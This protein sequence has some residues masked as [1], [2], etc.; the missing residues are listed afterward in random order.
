MKTLICCLAFAV[1]AVA[2]APYSM[3]FGT[4]PLRFEENR[5]QESPSVR[6]IARGSRFDVFLTKQGNVIRWPGGSVE[7]TLEGAS[8]APRIA[9]LEP[10]AVRTNYFSGNHPENWKT[11]LR[12]Y[13]KVRYADVY[14]GIDL[15]FYGREGRLEYDFLVHAGADPASIRWKFRGGDG[16]RIGEKG[17]LL[18][19]TPRG[20]IEWKTPEIYQES[21]NVRTRV[22]GQFRL[23]GDTLWFEVGA[24]DHTRQLV[25]DPVLS[26]STF[27][28]G[29]KNDGA[30]KIAVDS[31]GNV[32][33]TGSTVSQDLPVSKTPFQAAFA[34][35]GVGIVAGTFVGDVFLA[36]FSPSG[37]LL[38]LTYL[39]GS[40]DE[41]ATGLVL[42]SAGDAYICGYTNSADFPKAGTPVQASFA[43]YGGNPFLR[44]GDGFI[45]KISPG[46]DKLLYS[47]YLG[48]RSDDMAVD[49]K[50]DSASNVYVVGWTLS[51]DFPTTPGAYQSPVRG[52]GGQPAT[53]HFGVPLI[54]TGDV[55]V[56]KIAASGSQLVFSSIIGGSMDDTPSSIAL[57][58]SNN[59]YFAGATLSANF[60]VTNGAFQ[61]VNRGSDNF[62]NF[63]ANMGDGF[64]G[65]LDSTGQRHVFATYLGGSGDDGI[66]GMTVD[67]N[68]SAW[69]TGSTES[70]DFPI[71]NRLAARGPFSAPENV[72]YVFGDAFVTQLKPD[73]SGLV[74]STFLGGTQDDGG[75]QIAL[76]PAGN[77]VVAGST[78]STDFPVTS[79]A[80]QPK[81]GGFGP[82]T[83]SWPPKGDGFL[84]I[85]AAGGGSM[86][87]SSYIGGSLGDW[88]DGLAVDGSGNA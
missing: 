52:S 6:Y 2:D 85:L 39:G 58:A 44:F 10:L 83:D 86:M 38:F 57:D 82:G 63:F 15:V 67:K 19:S 47:T 18:V 66:A 21:L 60:P 11:D 64:V 8:E 37:S 79:N 69:V 5:G 48:G 43:G 46:G 24:Y 77:I 45:A 20:E 7:A 4:L 74:F 3:S 51:T 72:D 54:V 34:G 12:S 26:F 32:Y 49:I 42:D 76:D 35:T 80:I 53:N 14:P 75:M 87:Y 23:N 1:T 73:G 61:M 81:F 28:G 36:K 25:I 84:V 50:L 41:A 88:V 31:N 16:L 29:S 65:K 56:A 59:V 30:S 40:Q 71:T 27:L 70:S 62:T 68:G 33:V 55:F 17:Q 22:D 9:G 78:A 13:A